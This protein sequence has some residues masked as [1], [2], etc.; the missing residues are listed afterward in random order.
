M[1]VSVSARAM[2]AAELMCP[3]EMRAAAAAI[4]DALHGEPEVEQDELA[5]RV[6][7]DHKEVVRHLWHLAGLEY[8]RDGIARTPLV[9][10][11]PVAQQNRGLWEKRELRFV[12]LTPPGMT[13]LSGDLPAL[14]HQHRR[15]GEKP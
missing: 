15:S 2:A 12:S 4:L 14:P 9:E 8:C 13:W 10:I 3:P 11:R 1:T 5:G 6:G 7:L